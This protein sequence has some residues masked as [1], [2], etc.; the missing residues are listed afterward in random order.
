M[1]L[2]VTGGAGFI[3]KALC[4]RLL[5]EGYRLT[6]LTSS[7]PKVASQPNQRWVHW[8]PGVSGDWE[9]SVAVCEGIIN[10]A[11]AP[12]AQ[13]RWTARRKQ[14]L[15]NSRIDASHS[16]IKAMARAKQRPQILIN[17]SAV[18][19][20]GRHG[21]EALT[22]SAPAGDDYLATLARLWEET[23]MKGESLGVRTVC[24]RIGVVLAGDGGALAKMAEPFKYFVGGPLGGGKQ[25]ISWIHRD[26]VIGLILEAMR[27]PAYRGPI[28]ATAPNPVTMHEFCKT[29]GKV[30]KRPSWFPVPAFGLRLSLGEMADVLL[31]GQRVLPNAAQKLGYQFRYSELTAALE[32]CLSQ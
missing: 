12:I 2:L 14:K 28:N 5:Q 17:A 18:G 31:T 29:L 15:M 1:H 11:G 9:K 10:L 24:L 30:M 25:W 7:T 21:D 13:E 22:E 20:Y 27:N 6:V 3:G 16:L 23:A 26:D 19:Y 32:A 8:V 4:E